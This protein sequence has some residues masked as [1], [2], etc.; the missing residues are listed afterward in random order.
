MHVEKVHFVETIYGKGIKF[1]PEELKQYLPFWQRSQ[2]L[3]K[4][5]VTIMPA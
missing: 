5:D 1:L 4:W 3:P 2:T